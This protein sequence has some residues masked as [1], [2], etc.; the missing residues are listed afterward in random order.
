VSFVTKSS[1]HSARVVHVA[2]QLLLYF[3]HQQYL[4]NKVRVSGRVASSSVLRSGHNAVVVHVVTVIEFDKR[5]ER[6][7]LDLLDIWPKLL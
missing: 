1:G 2:L 5:G 3:L 6:T 7:G 4:V